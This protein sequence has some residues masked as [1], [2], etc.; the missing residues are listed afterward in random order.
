MKVVQRVMDG[1]CLLEPT[2]FAD[3]RGSFYESYNEKTF[4]ELTGFEERFVQDNHSTSSKHV[5]RGIHYQLPNP[6]G[7]LVRCIE[8]EIWDVAVDLRRGS[9]TFGQWVGFELTQENKRQLWVPVGFGHGFLVL[10]EKAQV[11]YRTTALW[12]PDS[13]R[14]IRWNDPDL[15]VDWPTTGAP[16]LSSKDRL[17]PS[18][19]AAVTFE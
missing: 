8:G 17:A 7:K 14:S 18:L 6:Q 9:P 10:S 13:D 11:L 16:L 5:L 4:A 15:S 19:S 12:D 1:V 2:V 3:E